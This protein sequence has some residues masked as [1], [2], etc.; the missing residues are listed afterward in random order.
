MD[1][2]LLL[3]GAVLRPSVKCTGL[4]Q[5]PGVSIT[6]LRLP[7]GLWGQSGAGLKDA[8]AR[9]PAGPARCPGSSPHPPRFPPVVHR[10]M[11]PVGVKA[12]RAQRRHYQ[13]CLPVSSAD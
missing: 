1:I 5:W 6:A 11:G 9:D 7:P 13:S 12:L 8:G 3:A 4:E 10:A 2:I